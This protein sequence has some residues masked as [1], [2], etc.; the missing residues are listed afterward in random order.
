MPVVLILSEPVTNLRPNLRSDLLPYR[1][2]LTL[3]KLQS[4]PTKYDYRGDGRVLSTSFIALWSSVS[5][6]RRRVRCQVLGDFNSLPSGHSSKFDN[7]SCMLF[8]AIDRAIVSES[9]SGYAIAR[10]IAHATSFCVT[11]PCASPPLGSTMCLLFPNCESSPAARRNYL[12][13]PAVD[14]LRLTS[15][16]WTRSGQSDVFLIPFIH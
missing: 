15:C 10:L 12:L 3:Q 2:F 11:K 5:V 16:G 1:R 6:N 13:L 14:Q 4:T 8:S 9:I 7:Y